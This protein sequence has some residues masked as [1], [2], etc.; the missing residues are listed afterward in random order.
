MGGLYG[1]GSVESGFELGIEPALWPN[2]I[3]LE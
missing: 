1:V 2:A 3:D